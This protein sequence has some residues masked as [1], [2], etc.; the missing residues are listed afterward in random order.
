MN[1]TDHGGGKL[2]LVTDRRYF[3]H[4]Y[5]RTWKESAEQPPT[6]DGRPFNLEGNAWWTGM[7]E[8]WPGRSSKWATIMSLGNEPLRMIGSA[9]FFAGRSTGGKP[10]RMR[11]HR[12]HGRRWWNTRGRS[13]R[14]VWPRARWSA[15]PMA[16]WSP[17]CA[18]IVI[19]SSWR[20]RM[21]TTRWARPSRFLMMTAGHGRRCGRSPRRADITRTC[22]ACRVAISSAP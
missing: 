21:A 1:L 2:S 13:G 9:A 12:L 14:A 22:N 11:C 17:P 7:S 10:G 15:P 16:T 19:P 5:G 20:G 6:K 18:P 4:D 3:S 8:G